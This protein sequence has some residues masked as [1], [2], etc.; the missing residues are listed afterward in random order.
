MPLM[1]YSVL[2]IETL[3]REIYADFERR[4]R[5]KQFKNLFY[6]FWYLIEDDENL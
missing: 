6:C 4:G 3:D 2:N 5:L 1:A